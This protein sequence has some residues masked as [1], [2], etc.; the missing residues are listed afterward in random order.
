MPDVCCL[1][2]I[3]DCSFCVGSP[4]QTYI[5]LQQIVIVSQGL[6]P[7][8]FPDQPGMCLVSNGA[9]CV[10]IEKKLYEAHC[11]KHLSQRLK[12]EVSRC[13]R[14]L[15]QLGN[16][17]QCTCTCKKRR[18]IQ[19][20]SVSTNYNLASRTRFA[21]FRTY[22]LIIIYLYCIN[23]HLKAPHFVE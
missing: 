17:A 14:S 8:V 20:R 2:H 11:P 16:V 22:S 3:Y 18:C 4:V 13:S 9:E 12:T 23:C 15:R 21:A 5:N 1:V 7:L 19:T 6:A 10:L